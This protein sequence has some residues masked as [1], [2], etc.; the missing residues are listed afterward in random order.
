MLALATLALLNAGCDGDETS[1]ADTQAAVARLMALANDQRQAV[2]QASVATGATQISQAVA[3]QQSAQQQAAQP[4]KTLQ[5]AQYQQ[6]LV[7]YYA[8]R[9]RHNK[10]MTQLIRDQMAAAAAEEERLQQQRMQEQY[11]ARRQD[12]LRLERVYE[13]QRAEA[14]RQAVQAADY[15]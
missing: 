14:R 10:Q 2:Q 15:Q 4:E 5:D 7:D 3:K 8:A 12:R 6:A 11:E 9:T 1:E 13:E